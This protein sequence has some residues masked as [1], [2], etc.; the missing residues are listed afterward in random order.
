[1]S[2]DV[3]F[4]GVRGNLQLVFSQSADFQDLLTELKRKLEAAAAF[5]NTGTTVKV[6]FDHR[7]LTAA[8]QQQLTELLAGYGIGWEM[9]D[10]SVLEKAPDSCSLTKGSSDAAEPTLMIPRTL[11]GGQR[12]I[13]AHSIVVEGDVNPGAEVIAGGN[14][15]VYGTCRGM[16]HAGAFGNTAATITATMLLASQL[17]IAGL[18]A[19]APDE[20]D[21]PQYPETAKI[22]DGV[23]VIEP[24]NTEEATAWAKSS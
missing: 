13:H 17:R 1:M 14:I 19:R 21:K 22:K 18:I 23:V 24:A 10:G 3:V 7:M 20:M 12:V 15:S 4:K 6:P 8:E 16:A 9:L 5:F 11:R 2:Q